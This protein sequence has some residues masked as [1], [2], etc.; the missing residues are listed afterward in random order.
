MSD[1]I[2]VTIRNC[3]VN[4]ALYQVVAIPMTRLERLREWL[5]NLFR[6]G[7]VRLKRLL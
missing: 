6:S 4:G 3:R 5:L 1:K 2:D 7:S